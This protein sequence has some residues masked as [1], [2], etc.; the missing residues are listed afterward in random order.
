MTNEA[1]KRIWA[2]EHYPG[3]GAVPRSGTWCDEQSEC[4]EGSPEYVR[5]DLCAAGQEVRAGRWRVFEC[6]FGGGRWGIEVDGDNDA[7]PVLY[8]A[9]ID[10]KILDSVVMA[11]NAALAHPP[12]DASAHPAQ[13]QQAG[14]QTVHDLLDTQIAAQDCIIKRLQAELKVWQL[15]FRAMDDHAVAIHD[16]DGK[17]YSVQA[18]HYRA[19]HDLHRAVM[20]AKGERP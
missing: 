8:P 15:A 11:H 9:V 19:I 14:M 20:A 4:P 5:A 13:S 12:V 2:F 16:A 17:H 6:V 1:P 10:R 7:D 3:Q 18:R